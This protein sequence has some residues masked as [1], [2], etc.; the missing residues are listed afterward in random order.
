M[1]RAVGRESEKK[2]WGRAMGRG[3][4]SLVNG[5]DSVRVWGKVVSVQ[6][7]VVPWD[8][9]E[10]SF[11]WGRSMVVKTDRLQVKSEGTRAL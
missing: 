6:P 8:E 11:I 5:P 10:R 9:R 3:G 4:E 2:V 7:W 1:G